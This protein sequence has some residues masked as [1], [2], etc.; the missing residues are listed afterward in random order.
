MKPQFCPNGDC[1]AHHQAPQ[2]RWWVKWGTYST[3]I[4]G[5]V[6]RYKCKVCGRGFSAQTFSLDYYAKR[7]VGYEPLCR[8][9]SGCMGVRAL[10]RLFQ[11]V[12]LL[13]RLDRGIHR[14][15]RN[16][17]QELNQTE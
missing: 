1:T 16:Q 9:V 6:Q 17:P 3:A 7:R 4:G 8:A 13:K 10:G 14:N 12:T 2:G 11:S 15:Y 5:E